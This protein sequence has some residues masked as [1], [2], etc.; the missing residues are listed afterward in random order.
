[1][2]TNKSAYGAET[3]LVTVAVIGMIFSLILFD[4]LA[5]GSEIGAAV[6]W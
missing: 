3:G 2:K 6:V 5:M 4:N 1:M